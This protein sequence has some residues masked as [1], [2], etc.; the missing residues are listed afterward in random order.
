MRHKITCVLSLLLVAVM[1]LSPVGD[2]TSVL[3]SGTENAQEA[4]PSD[5]GQDGSGSSADGKTVTFNGDEHGTV[6]FV[7]DGEALDATESEK[8]YPIGSEVSFQITTEDSYEME[9]I[10]TSVGGQ[11]VDLDIQYDLET[12]IYSFVMPD[13][14]VTLDVTYLRTRTVDELNEVAR[15][16]LPSASSK[17]AR[18]PRLLASN[19]NTASSGARASGSAYLTVGDSVYYGGYETH[20]Y[21]ADRPVTLSLTAKDLLSNFRSSKDAWDFEKYL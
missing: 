19:A 4:E 14:D 6:Q 2:M 21:S 12:G 3:A 18:A 10:E 8:I 20:F 15:S 17:I 1:L 16:L 7:E 11:E 9:D 5:G 13:E